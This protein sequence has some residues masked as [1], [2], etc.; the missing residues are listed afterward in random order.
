M[1]LDDQADVYDEAYL[2]SNNGDFSG[3]VK[4]LIERFKKRIISVAIGNKKPIS[5]HFKK[6]ESKIFRIDKRFIESVK[7]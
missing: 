2:I 7:I 4:A 3:A 6:V 5:H 1:V